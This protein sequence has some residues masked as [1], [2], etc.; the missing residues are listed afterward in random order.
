[1]RVFSIT[2]SS[3]DSI[4]SN[5]KNGSQKISVTTSRICKNGKCHQVQC[6][7]GHCKNSTGTGM[8]SS[9]LKKENEKWQAEQKKF[10]KDA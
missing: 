3:S 6:L 8:K 10:L 1:M 4:V 5:G 9:F 7:N 2:G